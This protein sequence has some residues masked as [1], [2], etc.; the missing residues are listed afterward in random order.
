M[1]PRRRQLIDRLLDDLLDMD[2]AE[3]A[4]RLLAMSDRHPRLHRILKRLCDAS[5][6]PT[7]VLSGSI[8][9]LAEQ[10]NDATSAEE[11]HLPP[12]TR[13]GP[14]RV[15]KPAGRGG[16]GIVYEGERADGTF[17][18]RAAIKLIR[19]KTHDLENRLHYERQLMARLSHSGI[20]RLIDGGETP[21]GG[22]YLVMEWIDG[23]DLSVAWEPGRKTAAETVSL[24]QDLCDAMIHA[25][26][27]LVIHGDIKPGN[28]R[29]DN[30]GRLRLLDFGVSRL[31]DDG[32]VQPAL[33]R[34]LTPGFA[35]PELHAG[36]SADTSA[37]LW[38]LG[39]L[40]LWLLTG[41]KP[42]YLTGRGPDALAKALPACPRRA[43]LGWVLSRAC[44]DD[45][46]QRYSSVAEFSADLLRY[47]SGHAVS[48]RPAQPTYLLQRFVGRHRL[49][50]AL[51]GAALISLVGLTVL[52]AQQAHRAGIERDRAQYEAA[53]ATLVSD[54]LVNLFEQADPGQHLGERL[55]VYRLLELGRD[56]TEALAEAPAQ[57]AMM[58]A[59]LA[60]VQLALGRPEQAV[61]LSQQALA[62]DGI[63]DTVWQ[64]ETQLA[65]ASALIDSNR[66]DQAE[67]LLEDL[68]NNAADG[69]PNAH[70]AANSNP[71][72]SLEI[73]LMQARLALRTGNETMAIERLDGAQTL[74]D[75]RQP[76]AS[77]ADLQM[78]L[79]TA[80][81][82][83]SR[84][85][86][87]RRYFERA[88]DT[89]TL[90]RGA[91]H[92]RTLDSANFLAQSLAQLG[93][94]ALAREQLLNSLAIRKQVLPA[95]HPLI[96]Y[97]LHSIGSTYWLEEDI[98]N[99]LA[100]WERA[101]DA[102][103]QQSPPD[104]AE[105]STAQN[106]MA[107]ALIETGR[108]EE[109]EALFIQA[110]DNAVAVYGRDHLRVGSIIANQAIPHSRRGELP[111]A[112][113]LQKES[114]RIRRRVAGEN[115]HHTGHSLASIAGTYL[116]MKQLAEAERWLDKA[117]RVYDEIF[118][119]P[120]HPQRGMLRLIQHDLALALEDGD[121]EY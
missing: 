110:L 38:A 59:T 2:S 17:E 45:P 32:L 93:E 92:P 21:D 20:A 91:R 106:A 44:A 47:Q 66:F 95:G 53:K 101:L 98:D 69:M 115:H 108:L 70:Q 105:L 29:V 12:G 14:W 52:A 112:L 26:Q 16:M 1:T 79:G 114:L 24:F 42:A 109:A 120:E 46:A 22:G 117:I 76:S 75:N 88:L 100:W 39:A 104:L 72:L 51:A 116:R 87:A 96:A 57:Q 10:A 28:V 9:R 77:L 43:D 7:L 5:L 30:D 60:R 50:S 36:D 118:P 64:I 71:Q 89:N 102:R 82:Q 23:E 34:A 49:A 37:D 68:S 74:I 80:H 33:P 35:A 119:D 81:Y 103:L 90:A 107:L 4:E 15:L 3:R 25:H 97:N 63:T 55:S 41:D 83:A 65:Q 56:N 85:D 27:R 19:L 86:L 113:A 84:Y 11:N 31:L 111:E 40:L 94:I 18:M 121:A 62:I 54:F 6:A 99:A 78:L 58:L 48:A 73:R 67:Q 8:R 13:L 61:E